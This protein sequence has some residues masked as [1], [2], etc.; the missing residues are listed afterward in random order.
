MGMW[1]W[2]GHG[3]MAVGDVGVE[4][5]WGHGDRGQVVGMGEGDLGVGIGNMVGP[6][7]EGQRYVVVGTGGP[8]G[9]GEH[10]DRK[11]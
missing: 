8:R 9:H 11:M 1:G 5:W 4:T 6:Q 3:G 2:W 10:R 7:G